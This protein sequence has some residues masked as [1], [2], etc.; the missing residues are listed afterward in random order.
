MYAT[1]KWANGTCDMCGQVF[2][3]KQ[4]QREV[5]NQKFTGF[6]VCPE[7]MDAD[8]PQLQLGRTPIL[9][10]QALENPR[11]DA[12]VTSSRNLWGFAPVGNPSI[13]CNAIVGRVSVNGVVV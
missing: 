2:K 13:L 3:L 9:D 8:S 1:K 4:L 7:C 5:Y 11:P 12:G 6:L 10:P